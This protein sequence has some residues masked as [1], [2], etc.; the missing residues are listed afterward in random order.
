MS[1]MD[2]NN[3]EA[4]LDQPE[5]FPDPELVPKKKRCAGGHK[6]HTEAPK[7]LTNELAVVLVVEFKTFFCEKY[8][9]ATLSLPEE[10][11]VELEAENVAERLN[12]I[13]GA[14]EIQDLIGG[15]TINGELEMLYNCVVNF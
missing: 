14:E 10:H 6:N 8:G 5:S 13:Q 12:D 11:F 9:T 7:E 4:L 15:E 1:V 3:F 2:I